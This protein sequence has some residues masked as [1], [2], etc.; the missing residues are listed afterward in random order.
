M[1]DEDKIKNNNLSTIDAYDEVPYPSYPYP[2][3]HP[4]KLA[5]IGILFGMTP[6]PVNNCRVLELGCSSGNNIIAM[7]SE[8]PDSHF[9][10][11]DLSV[12]EVKIAINKMNDLKLKNLELKHMSITDITPEFGKFDYIIAHGIYSWV[13]EIVRKKILEI[14]KNNLNKNGIAYVSYNTYPGW[15]IYR[16]MRDIIL[17]HTKD[18]KNPS[19][20]IKEARSFIEF[21][22]RTSPKNSYYNLFFTHEVERIKKF[23]DN[24]F[25]HDFMEDI[26]QPFYFY[27]FANEIK[28]YNLQYL[29]ECDLHVTTSRNFSAE[30]SEM[31]NKLGDDIIKIEQYIDFMINRLFRETLI[32]DDHINL[33][34][35]V[36]PENIRSLYFTSTLEPVNHSI[37]I[38][39]G[40]DVAFKTK[41]GLDFTSKGSNSKAL[42]KFLYDNA[43]KPHNL[44]TIKQGVS[45]ILK[46]NEASLGAPPNN[47]DIDVMVLSDLL[48]GISQGFIQLYTTPIQI[49]NSVTEKPLA[50]ELTR[51]EAARHTWVTTQ[52]HEHIIID[53]FA[54][55]IIPLLDG[56]HDIHALVDEAIKLVERGSV[57]IQKQGQ[58]VT[59]QNELKNILKQ[60]I[61]IVLKVCAKS[62]LLIG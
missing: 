22:A 47:N 60:Q 6:A 24:Y 42:W 4:H 62:G 41:K 58:P 57:N 30:V 14:C 2:D 38:E 17:Y 54:H 10:G 3:T 26:N 43:P 50:A 37:P 9:V 44:T 1:A 53:N 51:Y 15:H 45:D 28:K 8:L 46:D 29:R 55:H 49:C 21:L 34:R 61:D 40:I 13:P 20:A 31:L 52:L 59:D 32:C 39:P 12:N 56:E 23:H 16:M 48:W 11:I 27:E 35:I 18:I 33:H 5:S 25:Y 19:E 7:A 36:T